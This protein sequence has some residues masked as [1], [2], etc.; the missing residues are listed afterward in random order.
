MTVPVALGLALVTGLVL[1]AATPAVLRR[2]PE[3]TDPA[4]PSAPSAPGVSPPPAAA[5][6]AGTDPDRK[7]P[8]AALATRAFAAVV[9][10]LGAVTALAAALLAPP[11][12]LPG[13]LVLATFGVLL[14][15]VDAR[16]TWLPLPLTRPAWAATAI[17]LALGAVLG[18]ADLLLRGLAGFVLAGAVFG[19]VWWFSRGGFG[20]GDVRYAPLVGAATASVDWSVLAWA[21][22]LGSL[23]GALV[24]VGRLALG[25]RGAFAYAP[26]ILAGAYL[27]MLVAW[28]TT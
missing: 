6:A 11:A 13:W 7:V 5:S 19:A 28:L 17:A 4:A 12:T 18:G 16:T 26:A 24:G 22:V 27:A 8:Y 14:A 3:P 10:A 9:A 15:A 1:F 21:L 2:L 23:V 25:R 20:F